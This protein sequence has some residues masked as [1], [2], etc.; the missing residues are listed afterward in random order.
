MKTKQL[1]TKIKIEWTSEDVIYR[2]K[3]DG[4]ELTHEQVSDV[5]DMM[6]NDHDANV[7]INWDFIS[8]CISEV[9]GNE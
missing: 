2:A 5:L 9:T 6:V 1:T 8:H 4:I 7:G 3:D